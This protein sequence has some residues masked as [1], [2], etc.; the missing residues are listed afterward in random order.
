M[1]QVILAVF[2]FFSITSYALNISV[3]TSGETVLATF[4]GNTGVST[5]ERFSIW[6]R[7][8]STSVGN[9]LTVFYFFIEGFSSVSTSLGDY[10]TF[11]TTYDLGSLASGNYR[12]NADYVL[13]YRGT[14]FDPTSFFEVHVG[15]YDS[16]GKTHFS[17]EEPSVVPLPASAWLLLSALTGLGVF[18]K[19]K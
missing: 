2:V 1:K 8:P 9:D 13:N 7:E 11:E 16:F 3:D 14:F 5:G 17:V 6:V 12:I 19:R 4:S 18:R 15:D 10:T